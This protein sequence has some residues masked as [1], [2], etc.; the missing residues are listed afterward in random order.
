MKTI[1]KHDK[2]P[3]LTEAA[4]QI[5]VK[6]AVISDHKAGFIREFYDSHPEYQGVG[7]V[8]D[9]H[10]NPTVRVDVKKNK[11]MC[12]SVYADNDPDAYMLDQW[13]LKQLDDILI[14][15]FTLTNEGN[16]EMQD[17]VIG[18]D[19]GYLIQVYDETDYYNLHVDFGH[20]HYSGRSLN[21]LFYLSEDLEGGETFFPVQDVQVQP[22]TG[23]MILFPP[24]WTH[25]HSAKPVTKG[26]KYV[27]VIHL[28]HQSAVD[29]DKM[30]NG[31]KIEDYKGA[32]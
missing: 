29:L 26:R 17:A 12:L 1:S 5:W 23:R 7:S 21:V 2:Y 13:I 11:T 27:L 22:T 28:V 9:E 10:G 8:Q 19:E 30:F 20:D 4:P 15:W 6:D 32:G 14:E 18:S 31:M 16:Y 25:P 3:E 24:Y